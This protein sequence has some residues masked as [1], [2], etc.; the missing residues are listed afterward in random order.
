M[1]SFKLYLFSSEDNPMQIQ[2]AS[3]HI[4]WEE[5]GSISVFFL[6][7]FG[8]RL[9]VTTTNKSN[10][11]THSVKG[12]WRFRDGSCVGSFKLIRMP[13]TLALGFTKT[14]K[15]TYFLKHAEL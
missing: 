11:L 8:C 4:R 15:I 6:K 3:Y 14:D 1:A 5:T 10:I 12:S 7:N 13:P 9:S 2:Q